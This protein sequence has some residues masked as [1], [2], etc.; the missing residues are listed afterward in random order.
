MRTASPFSILVNYPAWQSCHLRKATYDVFVV[1]KRENTTATDL[2][3][4]KHCVV[5]GGLE[6]V[7]FVRA[8]STLRSDLGRLEAFVADLNDEVD[9]APAPIHSVGYEVDRD[10]VL[11][12]HPDGRLTD[13]MSRVIDRLAMTRMARVALEQVLVPT[14]I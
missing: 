3:T 7:K 9:V 5:L 4:E 8:L 13:A 12:D 10:A 14:P 6:G 2:E 1:I 11:I